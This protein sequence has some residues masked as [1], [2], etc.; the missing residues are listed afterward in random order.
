MRAALCVLA[1][2][3]AVAAAADVIKIPLQRMESVR[4]RYAGVGVGVKALERK[5]KAATSLGYAVGGA[6][7]EPLTN[8][9]DAQYFGPIS[10]GTPPQQFTVIFD[11]GSSNLWVPSKK[12]KRTDIAC[13]LHNK[14]DSTSSSTYVKNGTDFA[15]RYGTG[16]LTGFLSTDTVTV[17]GVAVKGQTFAEAVTQPGITFVAAKFDGI[18]GMGYSEIS[19]DGVPPVFYSMVQQKL[20]PAPIFS[21]YL[22]RDA[23]ASAGGELTLGGAD[24]ARYTGNVTWVNV[25]T[26][27]YWQFKMDGVT[28]G[29]ASFCKGGCNAIADTGTSLLAGPSEEVAAINKAIGATPINPQESMVDCSK[30]PTMPDISFEIAGKSFKLTAKQYV[31]QVS[32]G[33]QTEC[34]SGFTGLNVP[35]PRGPLWI[36]GDVF[37]GVYYTQFDLGNNRVGFAEA[38]N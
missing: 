9:Q 12:C 4:E 2:L 18:L 27:G 3:V 24:A 1:V 19:V 16:S 35:P 15:I 17:A 23:S 8:Y 34:L 33:G 37:L 5:Y 32:A 6:P 30:I 11:T 21:F 38:K 22:N 10:I 28:V 26:K 13:L 7:D 31:L 25:T 14:Y 29:S 36:L 20:V